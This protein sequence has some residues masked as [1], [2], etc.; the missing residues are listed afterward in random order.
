MSNDQV[1]AGSAS[2]EAGVL[3]VTSS[4]LVD[5]IT[6]VLLERFSDPSLDGV[7]LTELEAQHIAGCILDRLGSPDE[8][9]EAGRKTEADS[10]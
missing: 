9:A 8:T 5:A 7:A 10:R 6:E 3:N 4:D 2:N 1:R